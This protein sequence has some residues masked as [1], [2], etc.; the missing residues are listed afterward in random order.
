MEIKKLN[1]SGCQSPQ[2]LDPDSTADK[3]FTKKSKKC[4]PYL[5]TYTKKS[6]NSPG[7]TNS[8]LSPSFVY[9]DTLNFS[10]PSFSFKRIFRQ[11]EV[12]SSSPSHL[13]RSY[14]LFKN[15][16]KTLINASRSVTNKNFNSD[17][18]SIIRIKASGKKV[19]KSFKLYPIMKNLNINNANPEG[20]KINRLAFVS[21]NDRSK[22]K[23]TAKKLLDTSN[24]LKKKDLDYAEP[25]DSLRVKFDVISQY[26]N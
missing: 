2:I 23:K 16:N 24:V 5:E 20:L 25:Q 8:T 22:V 15:Q 10:K 13:I 9:S 19:P 12:T 18:K 3:E 17:F 6:S 21:R 7:L 14:K 11:I 26:L 4:F 1:L